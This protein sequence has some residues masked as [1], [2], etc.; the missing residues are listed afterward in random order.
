MTPTG[1]SLAVF[2]QTKQGSKRWE[3]YKGSATN[4]EWRNAVTLAK[5]HPPRQHLRRINVRYMDFDE[6]EGEWIDE[7][8]V[9]S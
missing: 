1:K 7:P 5:D 2:G 3:L 8:E 6:F 4:I 9:K